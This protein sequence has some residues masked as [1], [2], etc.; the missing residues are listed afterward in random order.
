MCLHVFSFV[1]CVCLKKDLIPGV[2]GIRGCIGRDADPGPQEGRGGI[3][4]TT[5]KAK[6]VVQTKVWQWHH[7]LEAKERIQGFSIPLGQEC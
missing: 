3:E 4:R 2:Q 1:N 6:V 5:G 7:Q